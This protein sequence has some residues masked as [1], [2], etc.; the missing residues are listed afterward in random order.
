M[1]RME[2]RKRASTPSGGGSASDGRRRPGQPLR[3]LRRGR[4]RR[5]ARAVRRTQPT[6][7]AAGK[8]GKP[9]DR[10]LPGALRGPRLG[11]HGGDA[12]RRLLQRRSPSGGERGSP[13]R[14]R[15]RDRG[16]AGDRRPRSHEHR[17]RPSS[18]PAG[19]A[20]P[21][22][23]S[24]SRAAIKG[25]RHFVAR[26]L[27][28]VEIDAD[29]RIVGAR[30]VR[31]RRHRR[32]LRGARRPVPRRRSGRPRA[33]VVGHRAGYAALN[34][35]E[36]PPTTPDWVNIDHRRATAF[37]S[38]DLTAYI[39]AAWDLTPDLSIYIEAVHRLN[40]LGAV[41]THAAHGTSQEGFDAEWRVIDILTV[42]GDLINR[43]E[44]FDEADLDAA[45]ARSTSSA[46]GA[47]AG[48]RG[49]PSGRT[50]LDVLRG[51]RLG[52]NG[53]DAGRRLFHRRSPA[54]RERR[55]PTRSGCRDRKMRAAA[56]LGFT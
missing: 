24:A 4:P 30:R 46:A 10:A 18:R 22:C 32:R 34:R 11:R 50:L 14:S 52:R 15:C 35:H 53:G 9:S 8:R 31:P 48:K 49:K 47:A 27:G 37:A 6:D 40:D 29:E 41:V 28:I 23:V 38:G 26:L 7:T 16:H 17:R 55:D 19:S 12:G 20:S 56:D 33:H 21:S 39:R 42:E 44:I 51:P 2:P 1:R 13:T 36:L 25:P 43:C 5:R 54:G 45:L 3:D